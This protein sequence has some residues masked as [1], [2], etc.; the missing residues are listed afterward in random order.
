[1]NEPGTTTLMIMACPL[2]GKYLWTYLRRL[3]TV[4]ELA[5]GEDEGINQRR[6]TGFG[7]SKCTDDDMIY[8]TE[9]MEIPPGLRM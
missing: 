6:T 8:E 5:T 1:M 7:M 9:S 2:P 4:Y 3:R